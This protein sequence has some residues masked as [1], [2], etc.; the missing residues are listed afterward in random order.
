MIA[1]ALSEE[2]V[3]KSDRSSAQPELEMPSY[4][5]TVYRLV[6]N[7]NNAARE[8]WSSH[9]TARILREMRVNSPNVYLARGIIDAYH[10]AGR[11]GLFF[12]PPPPFV[13]PASSPERSGARLHEGYSLSHT[14]EHTSE[15]S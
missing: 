8:L 3:V 10:F 6:L 1:P 12:P 4:G 2:K 7:A 13:I 14:S 5:A 15:S 11:R 9:V